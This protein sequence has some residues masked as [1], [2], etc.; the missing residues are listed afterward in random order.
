MPIQLSST[1]DALEKAK[2]FLSK[3]YHAAVSVKHDAPYRS[4]N[5]LPNGVV[6]FMG[7]SFS[8]SPASPNNAYILIGF[9]IPSYMTVSLNFTYPR[10]YEIFIAENI[11]DYDG[12]E[13]VIAFQTNTPYNDLKNISGINYNATVK[14]IRY[15]REIPVSTQLLNEFIGDGTMPLTASKYPEEIGFIQTLQQLFKLT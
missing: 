11:L 15:L 3:V 14:Y 12:T 10:K 5:Y 1:N 2:L 7:S 8:E 13:N 6:H 9:E 4:Y